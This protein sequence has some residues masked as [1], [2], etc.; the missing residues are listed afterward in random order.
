[1]PATIDDVNSLTAIEQS[2]LDWRA[3]FILK[4]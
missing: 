1:M 4:K 3:Q 2:T